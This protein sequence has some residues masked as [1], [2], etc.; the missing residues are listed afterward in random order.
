M[1]ESNQAIAALLPRVRARDAAAAEALVAALYPVIIAVVER[2]RPR[3][4]EAADITQEV[5]LKLFRNLDQFRGGAPEL[6]A[7]TRRT[8]FTT[9]LNLHRRRKSRPELRWADL[10]EDQ[11]AALDTVNAEAADPSPAE[12]AGGHDLLEAL[13]SQ[14]SPKERWLVEM[15]DVEQCGW[16]EVKAVTGWSAVN[17]RVRLFR[18]RQKLRHVLGKLL[19]EHEPD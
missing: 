2:R 4:V 16:E 10:S 14:L 6:E 5:F 19:K 7:W 1:D 8:A 18:A 9:C 13:L 12:Q 3:S 17:I 15:V 11:V